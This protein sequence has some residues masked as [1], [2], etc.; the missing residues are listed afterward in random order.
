MRLICRDVRVTYPHAARAAL[1]K[2]S[3]ELEP[4][5]RVALLGLNG[6]GKTTLLKALVGLLPHEGEIRLDDLPITPATLME[7]RSRTGF[8]FNVPEDQLL[9]PNVLDDVAFGLKRR[10]IRRREALEKARIALEELGAA[11]LAERPVYDLSHG[12]KLRVALAGILVMNPGLLL[13]DEPTAGLDP[14]GKRKL[15]ELLAGLDAAMLVATHDIAFAKSVCGR[16][17]LLD[18]DESGILSTSCDSV[19]K[20]WSEL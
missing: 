17:L 1:D 7:V 11:D 5:E 3:F 14:P 19:L 9:F 16:A 20:T 6:S 15:G 4:G 8:L 12:Q 18:P 10:K 2:I 13:L